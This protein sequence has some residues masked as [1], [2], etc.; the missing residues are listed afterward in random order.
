MATLYILTFNSK[1][2]D[3]LKAFDIFFFL[4]WDILLER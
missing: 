1:F 3:L 4:F 2:S